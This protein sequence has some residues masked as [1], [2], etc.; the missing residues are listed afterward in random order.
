MQTSTQENTHFQ[1]QSEWEK[2]DL[3]SNS[4]SFRGEAND[5]LRACL[6]NLGSDN[7]SFH[8]VENHCGSNIQKDE[9]K[10]KRKV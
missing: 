6:N 10:E 7:R 9:T 1:K 4:P 3:S 8:L 5:Y 2:K